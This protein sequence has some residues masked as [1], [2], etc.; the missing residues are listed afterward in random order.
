M[1]SSVQYSKEK[2]NKINSP[3]YSLRP[4]TTII[5]KTKTIEPQNMNPGPG[6]YL[7][8]E[9]NPEGS[10]KH[11]SKFQNITYGQSKSVRFGPSGTPSS[12]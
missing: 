3:K 10:S 4:K 8:P 2:P 9:L 12:I 7:N 11:T 6:S 1:P 5:D